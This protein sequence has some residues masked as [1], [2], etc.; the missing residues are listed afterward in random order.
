M[1]LAIVQNPHAQNPKELWEV[2][3]GY[4]RVTNPEN[5]NLDKTGFLMLKERLRGNP[6]IMVK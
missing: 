3:N 4:E 2:L 1:E 5:D 6:R